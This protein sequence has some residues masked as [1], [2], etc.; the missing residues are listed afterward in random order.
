MNKRP[1]LNVKL[2]SLGSII[3]RLHYGINICSWWITRGKKDLEK[4]VRLYPIRVGWQTVLEMNDKNF[5]TQILEGNEKH[6]NYPGYRCQVGLKFSDIEETPSPAIT[7]LYRR[8]CQNS[9][10]KFSG[11]QVL[12]WDDPYL[13]EQSLTNIEFRPFIIKVSKFII[14]ITALGCPDKTGAGIGYTAMFAGEHL[15][16]YA[17]YIQRIDIDGCHI[18]IYQDGILKQHF[19]GT[20]PNE[21]W[22]TS[23]KLKKFHGTQLFG[24]EHPL[25]CQ[26]LSEHRT[27]KCDVT[28]WHNKDIMNH[29]FNHYLRRCTISN[30]QWHEFF[31]DWKNN[32]STIIELHSS[33]RALYPSKHNFKDRELQAWKAMLKAAGCHEITPFKDDQSK[34]N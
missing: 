29:L 15:G 32:P 30:I 21:V 3:P 7:S 6:E 24:L 28:F 2:I 12:G 19:I 9:N 23:K 4:G 27:P 17:S 26:I 16:K 13:L 31:I 22:K 14:Y 10:T 25:T 33:L 1:Q 8:V 18:E 20:T 34:V 11:P 5:Y